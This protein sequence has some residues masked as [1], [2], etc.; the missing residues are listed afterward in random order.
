MNVGWKM[1]NDSTDLAEEYSRHFFGESS[2]AKK[3]KLRQRFDRT[4][5]LAA[6]AKH[7]SKDSSIDASLNGCLVVADEPQV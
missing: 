3:L 7:L 2:V 5:E 4:Y 1:S 6:L